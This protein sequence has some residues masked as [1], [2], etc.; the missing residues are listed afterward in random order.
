MD[1]LKQ[2][3]SEFSGSKQSTAHTDNSTITA[4]NGQQGTTE[5]GQTANGQ[6][7]GSNPTSNQ[8][9]DYGDKGTFSSYLCWLLRDTS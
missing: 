6:Q 3:A 7:G 2:A 4:A 5:L 8:Q 1:F 9:K